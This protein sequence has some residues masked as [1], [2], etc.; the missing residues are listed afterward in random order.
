MGGGSTRMKERMEGRSGE[1][2][3]LQL[4]LRK[5]KGGLFV[6]VSPISLNACSFSS[7]ASATLFYIRAFLLFFF[8]S[9]L[10]LSSVCFFGKV[11]TRCQLIW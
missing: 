6:S 8:L 7:E 9:I 5:V 3:V 2:R 1:L 4:L 11:I 10:M